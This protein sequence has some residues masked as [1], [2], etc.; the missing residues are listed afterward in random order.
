MTPYELFIKFGAPALRAYHRLE[1]FGEDNVPPPGE[2]FI[3]AANHSNWF[4]W[5]GL[6]ISA[7]LPER[8][9]RWVSWS[10]GDEIPLWDAAVGAFDA[11][12]Y[13]EKKPFPYKEISEDILKA[14]GVIGIFP[15][16]NNNTIW[17]RY[18]LRPFMPGCIRMSLMSGAPILPVAVA[19][20]EEASPILWAKEN[21]KE[22][23]THIVA[24]L[25]VFP[26]KV[27]VRFGEPIHPKI[28]KGKETDR[29][30]LFA[31]AKLVQSEV[32]SLLK[33]YR[34]NARAE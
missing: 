14:G 21:E 22:P 6:T 23:I 24:P 18:R 4:G 11:I 19:G 16:G 30:A 7:A 13:N 26:T 15:E 34:G 32:L 25:A 33:M 5:D 1:I 2:G 3:I 20:I 10:Y 27:T 17:D 9:I 31:A 12:L 8:H 29:A 28:E